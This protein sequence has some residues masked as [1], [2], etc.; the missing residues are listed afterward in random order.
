MSSFTNALTI[1][2]YVSLSGE[3]WLFS[4]LSC[5]TTHWVFWKLKNLCSALSEYDDDIL[6]NTIDIL[7]KSFSITAYY[8]STYLNPFNAT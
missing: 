1:S 2:S 7:H 6:E 4:I 8:A 5:D 3:H